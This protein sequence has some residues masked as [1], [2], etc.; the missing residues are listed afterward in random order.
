MGP[1]RSCGQP[2]LANPSNAVLQ[3]GN[4]LYL[5]LPAIW[6]FNLVIVLHFVLCAA[7]A[8]WLARVLGCSRA[9]AFAC[10]AVFA[11]RR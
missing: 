11:L 1:F 5:I 10:G 3:P 6:A 4:V 2:F 9:A 7:G 8:W